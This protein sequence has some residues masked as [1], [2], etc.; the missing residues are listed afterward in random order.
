MSKKMEGVLTNTL[1]VLRRLTTVMSIPRAL[2]DDPD[3]LLTPDEAAKFLGVDVRTLEKWRR[4]GCGPEYR[5]Q[6]RR[7]VR[8]PL[9]S[10]RARPGRS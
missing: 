2:E 5:A 3:R 6:G 7:C 9:G 10:L 1:E 4:E 8:Y